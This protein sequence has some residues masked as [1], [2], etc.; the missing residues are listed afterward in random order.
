M[1]ALPP[2]APSALDRYKVE[3]GSRSRR[4]DG[5]PTRHPSAALSSTVRQASAVYGYGR[6]HGG[7]FLKRPRSSKRTTQYSRKSCV[8]R[9]RTDSAY[10]GDSRARTRCRSDRVR[11]NLRHASILTTSTY[12]HRDEVSVPNR[13]PKRSLSGEL[14]SN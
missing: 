5:I 14:S 6:S 13:R 9:A 3:K 12:S 7:S 8:A 11:D 4:S 2:F 1:V 10:A